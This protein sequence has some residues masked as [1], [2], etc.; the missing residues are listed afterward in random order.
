FDGVS[1]HN[2]EIFNDLRGNNFAKMNPRNIGFIAPPVAKDATKPKSGIGQNDGRWYDPWGQEYRVRLDLD[3][4]RQVA[5]PY[6]KNAGF[7]TLDQG[8][9][10]WSLGKDGKGGSGDKN[11][12]DAKD[13]VVS[14]Q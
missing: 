3:Y 2:D 11:S 9:L 8:V 6:S 13:D 5:N 4:N 7:T 1:K 10:A 12:G 14:W